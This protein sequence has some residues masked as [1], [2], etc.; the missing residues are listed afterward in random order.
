MI[1]VLVLAFARLESLQKVMDSILSQEHGDIY[2]SCDAPNSNIPNSCESV[3][4]YVRNL[5]DTGVIKEFN[6]RERNTG[7]AN[8]VM[9]GID[10]FFTLEKSGLIVEDDVLLRPGAMEQLNHFGEYLQLNPKCFSINLRND[11]P[12]QF[13]QRTC[14][15]FRYSTLVNSHG[16]FTSAERWSE[17]RGE[18]P[19]LDEERVSLSVPKFFPVLNRLA[20]CEDIKF[21]AQKIQSCT[22]PWD[23]FWQVHVFC[24]GGFTL[25][26]NTNYV[27]YIGYDSQATHHNHEIR[28]KEFVPTEFQKPPLGID[29]FIVE[30]AEKFKFVILMRHSAPRFFVRKLRV[31]RILKNYFNW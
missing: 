3:R 21:Q 27:D 8:G 12:Q 19:I 17:F 30:E 13:L 2:V 26:S 23:V 10:W 22:H 4:T 28:K 18:F 25:N 14:Y 11:I 24:F 7:I 1:P 16:W 5:K 20:F 9:E 31:N 6:M 29:E 15:A